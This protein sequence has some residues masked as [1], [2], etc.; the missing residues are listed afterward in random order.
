MK[1]TGRNEPCPCGSGKKYKHCCGRLAAVP[2]APQAKAPDPVVL[3]QGLALCNQ[4][5]HGEAFL[6][7]QPVWTQLPS[8]PE[9]LA[10]R[11]H[12]ALARGQLD[13]A[14]V[15]WA[16]WTRVQPAHPAAWY[17]L[18]IALQRLGRLGEAQQALK[19]SLALAPQRAQTH[20]AIGEVSMDLGQLDEALVAYEAASRC[21]PG[22]VDPLNDRARV[23]AA[24]GDLGAAIADGRR[25]LALQPDAEF[26]QSN[27]L[28]YMA[29]DPQ[30]TVDDYACEY[31]RFS[32][33]L[34]GG[35]GYPPRPP[36][37]ARAPGEAIRVGYVSP[38]FRVHAI[39]NFIEPILHHGDRTRFEVFAYY[40][41]DVHDAVTQRC[42]A[43][44]AQWR[45]CQNWNDAQLAE[46]I[47]MDGIDILV[48]LAG[49]TANNRVTLFAHR[50]APV[51]ITYLGY[52][53]SSGL[54]AM[55]YRITDAL[56]DPIGS[57]GYYTEALLRLPDSLFCYRPMDD[58][59]E[60][61]P[62][63]CLRKGH[64]T[65]A[66]LAAY[67][68]IDEACLRLWARI[69][70]AVPQSRLLMLTVPQGVAQAQLLQRWK[71]LGV[72]PARVQLHARLARADYLA[73]MHEADIALDP[74]AVNSPTTLCETIWMGL[75]VISRYGQRCATRAGLSVLSAAGLGDLAVADDDA[76][77]QRAVALA[78]DPQALAQARQG[79][80]ERL[81]QSPLMD[82]PRFVRN[83]EQIYLQ[84]LTA[85]SGKN[86]VND[87]SGKAMNP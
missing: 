68:K 46:V 80:R 21:E 74:I 45:H 10:Q 72:D 15:H 27:L 64:I 67:N 24:R 41:G 82:A 2:V 54:Q 6:L 8:T 12:M 3:Q 47:R 23:H 53:G 76:Y 11:G 59:P 26:T 29:L 77:V 31:R 19:H 65:F 86:R 25:A 35:L 61:Q 4:G 14:R 75:P 79:Q 32:Q 52:P 51:Q 22:W 57:E 38:D 28:F 87:E 81:R 78:A 58:V 48:D 63:P 71:A 16:S 84:L 70:N 69:L 60:V 55:D 33:R 39:A 5:R 43:S 13:E 40:N 56:S 34:E 66:S 62:A 50:P 20:K 9:W 37:R 36:Q 30:Q 18:G 7:L 1:T 73:M 17:N 49:H 85:A 83:L 44:V 42:R